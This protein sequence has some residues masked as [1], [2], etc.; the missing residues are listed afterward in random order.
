MQ[1]QRWYIFGREKRKRERE[2]DVKEQGS[3]RTKK[4]DE[5][6]QESERT[7]ERL[8]MIEAVRAPNCVFARDAFRGR[9]SWRKLIAS[10]LSDGINDTANAII[11]NQRSDSHTTDI[12]S[13]FL[14][15]LIFFADAIF[16]LYRRLCLYRKMS[17]FPL[18]GIEATGL[19]NLFSKWL[20]GAMRGTDSLQDF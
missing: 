13:I 8:D 10:R 17:D 20:F 16:I 12:K 5:R 18:E 7:G 4:R 19:W 6:E 11:L 14:F 3:K 1:I 9:W 15:L 2:R